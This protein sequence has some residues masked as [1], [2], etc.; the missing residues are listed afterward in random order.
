MLDRA[1]LTQ[2]DKTY[3][4]LRALGIKRGDKYHNVFFDSARLSPEITVLAMCEILIRE[5]RQLYPW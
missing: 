4:L 5:L 2:Q 3:T 1:A